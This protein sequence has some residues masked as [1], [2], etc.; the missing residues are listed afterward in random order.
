MWKALIKAFSV[1]VWNFL[2]LGM[3][4]E[5]YAVDNKQY[6]TLYLYSPRFEVWQMAGRVGF[7]Y[8]IPRTLWIESLELT[9]G[10][11]ALRTWK[12]EWVARRS[13]DKIP[14]VLLGRSQNFQT[15]LACFIL[16]LLVLPDPQNDLISSKNVYIDIFWDWM[17][18][19]R[20]I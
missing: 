6:S 13:D 3:V 8:L 10:S 9:K 5:T 1:T 18:K 2:A 14:F 4:L 15:S 11:L 16:L 12:P 20:V 7:P 19:T 17:L